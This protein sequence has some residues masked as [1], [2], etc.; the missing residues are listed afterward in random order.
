[1][2]F[3]PLAALAPR[4][5]G[6]LR[7]SAD[8]APV[9]ASIPPRAGRAGGAGPSDP[10]CDVWFQTI[11]PRYSSRSSTDRTVDGAQP[12]GR[13]CCGRGAGTPSSL[14]AFVI[15]VRPAPAA[16]ISKMRRTTAASASLIRR[17]TCDRSPVGVEHLDVVVAE[18]PPAA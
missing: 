11:T 6:R 18:H 2:A 16:D 12:T 15:R 5:T 14:S 7:R 3:G 1:M 4:A 10:A 17:S 13:P 9:P 8:A